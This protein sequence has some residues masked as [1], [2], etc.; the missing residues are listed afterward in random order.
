MESEQKIGDVQDEIIAFLLKPESYGYANE[1]V[2]RIDTHISIIF[3]IGDRAFK[4]KRSLKFAYLN[5]ATL[6]R[7]RR[8]CETELSVNRRTAPELY[9]RVLAVT[10]EPDGQLRLDG[11][12]TP[13]E[14]LL[15]MKRFAQEMLFD[16]LASAD[17]L[18]PTLMTALADQIA[19][20]HDSAEIETDKT[21]SSVIQWVLDGNDQEIE[22]RI[23]SVFDRSRAESLRRRSQNAFR[24]VSAL[25]D[26]RANAGQLRRC[27]GDLHLRNICLLDGQPTLFDGIEFNDAI[28]L[29][30]VLYDL[31]FLL[32]D[33]EHRGHRD[34]ANIVF[35]RYMT[36]SD[37]LDGLSAM[38]LFLSCRAA[39]RA[40]TTAAAAAAQ[41]SPAAEQGLVD[42][43]RAY[44]D[45]ADEFLVKKPVCLIAIGGL[46][47]TGKSTLARRLAPL[48]GQPPGALVLRSDVIRKRLFG[49]APEEK[50]STEAYT[51][52]QSA[53][54]YSRLHQD[55]IAVLT[56]GYSVITDAVFAQPAE[57]KAI[58]DVACAAGVP[59]FGFWLD[60][61]VEALQERVSSRTGDASDADAAVVRQQLA[62]DIGPLDWHLIDAS[63]DAAKTFG[64]VREIITTSL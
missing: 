30:D 5:Y 24:Q 19:S 14:W 53:R 46:S 50:L 56:A 35:N 15:E 38:P 54:V 3:L 47:G 64:A 34:L 61:P 17:R 26:E 55:A 4:M 36:M 40:H 51:S 20:F 22:A 42:E 13:V 32:M 43:A 27:H 29:I 59:L 16:K 31:A 62:Y 23:S 21:G 6:E 7:R 18:S 57:R 41:T 28:T 48:E 1:T 58:E 33:L 9:R 8:F 49:I 2:T 52:E 12:G 37:Q 10:R 63:G 45:L 44:L 60:A 11:D 39:V 25:L